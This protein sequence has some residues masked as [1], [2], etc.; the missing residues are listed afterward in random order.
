MYGLLYMFYR[1]C[2]YARAYQFIQAETASRF[3]L[4]QQLS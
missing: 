4:I 2:P 3:G 1:L